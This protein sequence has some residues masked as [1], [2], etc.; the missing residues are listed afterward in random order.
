MVLYLISVIISGKVLYILPVFL[1]SA[2]GNVASCIPGTVGGLGARDKVMQLILESS[3]IS[4]SD[5]AM[6]PILYTCGYVSA[7]L[8]GALFFILDSFR[9]KKRGE[10]L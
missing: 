2:L 7:S 10:N 6:A 9:K 8:P 5:A 1:S 4:L 3:G